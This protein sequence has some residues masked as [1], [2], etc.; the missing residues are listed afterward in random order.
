MMFLCVYVPDAHDVCSVYARVYV[1]ACACVCA[2]TCPWA[3]VCGL[4]WTHSLG[5]SLWAS[6]GM[7]FSPACMAA[8]ETPR[9]GGAHWG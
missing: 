5:L 6:V 8:W 4:L 3:C 2:H 9:S 7:G 1:Y